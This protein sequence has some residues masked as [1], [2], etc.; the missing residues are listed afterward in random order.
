MTRKS[1][2]K[3]MLRVCE[4]IEQLGPCT[5]GS[6]SSVV[7]KNVGVYCDRAAF[8]G[9]VEVDISSRPRRYKIVKDW[10][11]IADTGKARNEGK[12]RRKRREFDSTPLQSIW[13]PILMVGSV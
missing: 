11:N 5:S 10:R 7:G 8:I 4:V 13:G 1:V 12:G 3:T 6:V 2:G 9:L